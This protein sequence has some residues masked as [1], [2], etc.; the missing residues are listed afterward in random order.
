MVPHTT[1]RPMRLGILGSDTVGS[2]HY[3]N[4]TVPCSFVLE[5]YNVASINAFIELFCEKC[6][7]IDL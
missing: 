2:V 5:L 7:F 3:A 4:G 6:F 1:L